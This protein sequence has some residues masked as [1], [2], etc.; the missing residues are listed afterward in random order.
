MA[1]PCQHITG[2]A[3]GEPGVSMETRGVKEG[4]KEQL[5]ESLPKDIG[6]TP[7]KLGTA[8]ETT[9][10]EQNA[11]FVVGSARLRLGKGGIAR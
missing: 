2:N 7:A 6:L 11:Q 3:S 4:S 5:I 1:P 8:A 9:G 10:G